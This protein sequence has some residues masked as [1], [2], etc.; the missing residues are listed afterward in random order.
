M[1][2][3]MGR[4]R[5]RIIRTFR[6]Y[7]RARKPADMPIE[8]KTQKYT[9][10]DTSDQVVTFPSINNPYDYLIS[11]PECCGQEIWPQFSRNSGITFQSYSEC[12]HGYEYAA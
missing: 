8:S 7:F 11:Q 9:T 5:Y 10:T 3:T 1:N 6:P 12:S 4:R 2:K